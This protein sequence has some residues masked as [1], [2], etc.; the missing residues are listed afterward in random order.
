M[1]NRFLPA[2]GPARSLTSATLFMT[3]GNGAFMT[4]SALYFTQVVGLSPARLGIG[5]SIAGLVGLL[6]GVPLGHLADR[7]GPRGTAAALIALNGVAAAGYLFVGSFVQFL[8]V[9]CAFVVLERGGRAALQATL[10]AV[11]R[12]T[13]LVRTRAYLRSVNNAGIALGALC[14]GFAIQLGSDTAFRVVLVADAL[15]F[16]VSALLLMTLPPTAAAPAPAAGEPR[17]AVLRDRPFA[18]VTLVSVVLS[19]YA[20]LLEIVLPLWIVRHTTAPAWIVTVLFLINTVCVVAFQVRVAKGVDDLPSAVTAFRRSG[21]VLLLCCL[22]FAVSS[23]GSPLV[24][25]LLLVAGG[26]V[27]VYGEMVL[28][29]AAWVVSYE[30][31]PPDKQGQYQGFF[32]TGYAASMMIAPVLLTSLLVEYGTPGWLILGAAFLLASAAMGPAV[33]WAARTRAHY[34]GSPSLPSTSLK[35]A[36]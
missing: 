11:L 3:M 17:L 36:S 15:S 16:L 13:E 18:L 33:R 8:L 26:A 21:A 2:R 30:L 12:G 19:L 31:A 4:C 10:A 6:A 23:T 14:A 5:L 9:A 35:G 20:V 28:S 25:G 7:R 29:A 32:F 22:L 1:D 34:F 27:H 24:S